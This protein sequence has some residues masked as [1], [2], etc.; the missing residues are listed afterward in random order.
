M[1][2]R[3]WAVLSESEREITDLK[4]PFDYDDSTKERLLGGLEASDWPISKEDI[5]LVEKEIKL[6][7]KFLQQSNDL[8]EYY[9]NKR[10]AF[11]RKDLKAS[12]DTARST[13]DTEQNRISL[14]TA[15]NTDITL[16]EQK[17]ARTARSEVGVGQILNT[18]ESPQ[19]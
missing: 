4:P 9:K 15:S 7:E 8:K 19:T 2:E 14:T 13:G 17:P 18:F 16:V 12:S 6:A 1:A 3:I 5:Q 10:D 11:Y